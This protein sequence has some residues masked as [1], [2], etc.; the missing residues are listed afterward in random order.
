MNL[1]TLDWIQGTSNIE[2]IDGWSPSVNIGQQKYSLSTLNVAKVQGCPGCGKKLSFLQMFYH[3]Y[4]CFCP[5]TRSVSVWEIY[6]Y[7]LKETHDDD[8]VIC[9]QERVLIKEVNLFAWHVVMNDNSEKYILS[10][11]EILKCLTSSTKV[12]FTKIFFDEITKCGWIL[13]N[14]FPWL[15]LQNTRTLDLFST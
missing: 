10:E 7:I 14:G 8:I 2:Y 3:L 1:P 9:I 4:Q 6:P 15:P 13:C 5:N 11:S 12:L